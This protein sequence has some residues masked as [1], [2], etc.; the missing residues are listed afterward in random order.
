MALFTMANLKKAIERELVLNFTEMAGTTMVN[1]LKIN[2]MV[3]ALTISNQVPF[4][5]ATM[6]MASVLAMVNTLG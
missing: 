1:G 6:N 5:K 2:V 4:T 3:K